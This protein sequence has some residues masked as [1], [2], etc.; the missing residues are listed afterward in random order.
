MCGMT[1]CDKP[2][3]TWS[4]NYRREC[5][6][7]LVMQWSREKRNEH[8]AAVKTRRGDVAVSELISEVNRQWT[9]KGDRNEHAG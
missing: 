5:E 8:Y 3:C 4:E 1:K 7:R 2:D 9:I 6:A